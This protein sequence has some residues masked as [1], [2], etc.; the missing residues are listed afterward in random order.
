MKKLLLTSAIL[1][2]AACG[3]AN[4]PAGEGAEVGFE[5]IEVEGVMPE[6]DPITEPETREQVT[7]D[8]WHAMTGPHADAVQNMVDAFH[9]QNP[10]VIVNHQHQGS[11]ADLNNSLTAAFAARTAPLLTQSTPGGI[12]N[13]I[14]HGFIVP[15]TEF[16]S[17]AFTAEELADIVHLDV[18]N[19]HDGVIWSSPFGISTRVLFYNRDVLDEFGLEVP[20][21]WEEIRYVAEATTDHGIN[22]FGMGWENAFWSEFVGKLAQLGGVYVDEATVTAQFYSPEGIQALGFIYDLIDVGYSR[23]AGADGFMSGVFGSGAVTMYIGS[24]AG[25]PHVTNAVNETFNW[26]TAPTPGTGTS[27]ATLFAG[28]DIAIIDSSVNNATPEQIRGAWEFIEFSL[29]PEVAAQWAND[30]GYIPIRYSANDLPL[31]QEFV[32]ENPTHIAASLQAPY[33]IYLARVFA[34]T[35][36][37]NQA[38]NHYFQQAVPEI[39][40]PSL[41]S[42]EDALRNAQERANE[43]LADAN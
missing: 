30:S 28:N 25:L 41:M 24:S 3:A 16:F 8:F 20:T 10:Y 11:Y 23:R 27:N 34:M 43:I 12:I 38:V 39:G 22:R 26:G 37:N 2:L 5:N 7:I 17:E 29:R 1:F 21:T 40:V 35:A 14:G 42:V 9:A 32:S 33:G 13:Y 31:R 19:T 6:L 15:L 18:R 4:E 36:V